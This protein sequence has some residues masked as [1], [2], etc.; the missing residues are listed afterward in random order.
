MKRTIDLKLKL[1]TETIR[2]LEPKQLEKVAGGTDGGMGPSGY[3]GTCQ[4]KY[5]R[6]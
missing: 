5:Y 1:K 2:A 3:T 6:R 4:T